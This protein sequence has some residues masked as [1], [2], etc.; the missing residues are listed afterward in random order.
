[1]R[2]DFV[3]LALSW[4]GAGL[5]GLFSPA[6]AC[7]GGRAA[8]GA[9][10]RLEGGEERLPQSTIPPTALQNPHLYLL[11]SVPLPL[12]AVELE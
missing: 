10:N 12:W 2:V 8:R 11:P 5:R 9:S 7:W 3:S 1:M 4:L 6:R